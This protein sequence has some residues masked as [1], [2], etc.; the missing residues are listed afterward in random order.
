MVWKNVKPNLR[1]NWDRLNE[2]QRRYA[3]EQY[4]LALVRRGLPIDHPIPDTDE[5]Q[6]AAEISEDDDSIAGEGPEIT[7]DEDPADIPLPNSDNEE[8]MAPPVDAMDLDPAPSTSK[9]GK[10]LKR[11]KTT[12]SGIGDGFNLPGT[13]QPQGEGAPGGVGGPRP[14]ALPRPSVTIHSYVRHYRKVHRFITWGIAYQMLELELTKAKEK[15]ISTPFAQVPWDRPY[16]YMNNSEWQILPTG[17]HVEHMKVEVRARNV[18]VAFE[19]NASST[20]LATLNQNKDVCYAVGLN[21]SMYVQNVQ[22]LTFNK[23]EPMIPETWEAD[24]NKK[25]EDLAADLY[26]KGF[27]DVDNTVPRHQMGIPTPLPTYAMVPY[28]SAAYDTGVMCLQHH[29]HDFDADAVSGQVFCT[30]NYKPTMGMLKR[31]TRVY[32]PGNHGTQEEQAQEIPRQGCQFKQMGTKIGIDTNGG[33]TSFEDVTSYTTKCADTTNFT[34]IQPIE[35]SQFLRFGENGMKPIDAQP[36]LHIAVQP[37]PALTTKS[38]Q[39]ESNGH[40]TDV[41]CYWELICDMTVNTQEPTYFPL[42][43]MTNVNESGAYYQGSKEPSYYKAMY[44]GLYRV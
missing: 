18:R 21:K 13:G 41:Q 28:R 23:E 39:G 40:F 26:G 4:N 27:K 2:G 14:L 37:T 9:G 38:L 11:K 10:T 5:P 29:Y 12:D 25:H 8:D 6:G 17:S 34:W 33:P 20:A 19:T 32:Y 36:S 43:T 31:P 22:Y 24:S 35:K 44:N 30:V 1:P 16:L 7:D 42:L 15:Q 3:W